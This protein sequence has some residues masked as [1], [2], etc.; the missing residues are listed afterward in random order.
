MEVEEIWVV[1]SLTIQINLFVL[2]TLITEAIY[3]SVF[4]MAAML[5]MGIWPH[6]ILMAQK[7][8]KD[9]LFIH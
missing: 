1:F 8:I 9:M 5:R 3:S 4:K 2:L 6:F 7:E